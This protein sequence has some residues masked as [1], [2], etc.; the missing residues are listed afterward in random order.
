VLSTMLF[1]DVAGGDVL[2]TSL[3]SA[4]PAAFFGVVASTVFLVLRLPLKD[5]NTA[6]KRP[7][8]PARRTRF[9]RWEYWIRWG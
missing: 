2:A 4:A 1:H 5:R 8:A 7:N 3:S 9:W 6:L